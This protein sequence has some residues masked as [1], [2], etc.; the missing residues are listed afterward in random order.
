MII[1]ILHSIGDILFCEPIYRHF[2]TKDGIKPTV[3][4]RDHL[5]WMQDYIESAR[6]LPAS[7]WNG[8]IENAEKTDNYLPLRFANQ[9]IRGFDKYYHDDFSNCMPDK[10]L[11]AGL[12]P[13]K[14]KELELKC[15]L[16]K[17]RE[18]F[19]ILDLSSEDDY[20]LVNEHCQAGWVEI[21]PEPK[22]KIVRMY[23]V[24]GYN[25]MDWAMIMLL[26]KE[27]HH[28]STSTFFILQALKDYKGEIFIYPRPN[29]DG[30]LGIS[31]LNPS[32]KYIAVK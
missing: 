5:M 12:D 20:I 25:V 21:K 11:L 7:Q 26:A 16:E 32:F 27:N 22:Y 2:W 4:I 9:I 14:W 19:A 10:Y 15:S 28:V 13:N 18:L 24:P 29:E 23:D 30:L 3:I 1:N 17:S 8:D 31:K 6:F